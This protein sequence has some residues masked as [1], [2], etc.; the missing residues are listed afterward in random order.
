MNP[1]LRLVRFVKRRVDKIHRV[2]FVDNWSYVCS[3]FNS[4]DVGTRDDSLKE[5]L[6]H[7]IWIKGPSFLYEGGEEVRCPVPVTARKLLLNS[8]PLTSAD[9]TLQNL[10]EKAP[11][12]YTLSKGAALSCCF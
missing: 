8:E 4:A 1:A 10:I 6:S 2:G 3:S 9:I 5:F 12:L 7:P 11:N